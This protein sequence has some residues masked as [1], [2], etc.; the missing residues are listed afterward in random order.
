MVAAPTA[1]SFKTEFEKHHF[2]ECV[3]SLLN[4]MNKD[5]KI[6]YK[7]HNSMHRDYFSPR[8]PTIIGKIASRFCPI[9][10]AL[11]SIASRGHQGRAANFFSQSYTSYLHSSILRRVT[12]MNK[13]TPNAEFAL[14]L[15]LP[16][17]KR[18]LIGGLSNTIWGALY[19]GLEVYNCIDTKIRKPGGWN[20]MLKK[21]SSNLLDLNIQFFGVP[22]CRGRLE[23]CNFNDTIILPEDR[24]GDLIDSIE[25]E[26]NS[27]ISNG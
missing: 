19:F 13:V 10:R 11:R 4:Q 8:I 7:P 27:N 26:L 9:G 25:N 16:G 21:D 17:V 3:L 22:Y 15:F 14:E 6:V 20:P 1:F 12:P 5:D 23:G 24:L 18:G 2:L